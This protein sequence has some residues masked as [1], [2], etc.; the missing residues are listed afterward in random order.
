MKPT[1]I[2][3]ILAL[4][5]ALALAGGYFAFAQRNYNGN[6]NGNFGG[7]NYN[8]NSGPG[9]RNNFGGSGIGTRNNYGGSGFLQSTNVPGPTDYPLFSQFI[10]DRNIFNP[11]RFSLAQRP[12]TPQRT[13]P[14]VYPTFGLVGTMAY[15]KGMFAFFDGNSAEY[16]MVLYASESNRIAGFIIAEV[17]PAG[18]KL[19]TAD[20]TQSMPLKIGDSLQ[21]QDD[22]SWNLG[23]SLGSFSGGGGGG[24]ASGFSGASSAMGSGDSLSAPGSGTPAAPSAAVQGNEILR[25]LMQERQQQLK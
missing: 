22:G 16:Q 14:K 25:R 23:G 8:D 17:T 20:K 4:A 2:T 18:V 12:I 10:A 19:Q 5:L 1:R 15:E 11:A 21:Q 9:G 24:V 6:G 13:R 3:T 7:R